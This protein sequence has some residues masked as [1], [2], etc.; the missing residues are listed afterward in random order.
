MLCNNSYK[1][2]IVLIY[3]MNEV[4]FLEVCFIFIFHKLH[5]AIL[6][7]R[8]FSEIFRVSSSLLECLVTTV[9][10]SLVRSSLCTNIH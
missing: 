2:I 5:I 3:H 1:S 7:T 9:F 6:F 8:L 4:D 10:F